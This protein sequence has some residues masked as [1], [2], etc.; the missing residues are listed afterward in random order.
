MLIILSLF[1]LF[2]LV[3]NR[4]SIFFPFFFPLF[5]VSTNVLLQFLILCFVLSY[6]GR[7][8]IESSGTVHRLQFVYYSRIRT[9]SSSTIECGDNFSLCTQLLISAFVHSGGVRLPK[10]RGDGRRS[11]LQQL[12][13]RQGT[14]WWRRSYT[15]PISNPVVSESRVAE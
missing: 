7:P 5:T 8:I 6:L 10:S 4:C 14:E 11:L 2:S 13:A 1:C 15:L 9:V 12:G 3:L